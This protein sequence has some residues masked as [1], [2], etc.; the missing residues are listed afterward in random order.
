MRLAIEIAHS[1]GTGAVTIHNCSHTGRLGAYAEMA[2]AAGMLGIVAVNAGGG[3]QLVAPFG[4]AARRISTNPIA[5]GAPSPGAHPI[6]LDM[7]TSVAPEGKVR[8]AYQ[9]GKKLPDGVLVDARGVPT[10]D[11]A[12]LYADPPGSLRP[13]GGDF[14]HKGF[15]LA[16]L[17]DILAG[18]LTGA[19]VC[20]EGGTYQG[21]GMLLIVLDVAHFTPIN[22][23]LPR[24]A[25]LSDWIKT[26][27]PAPGFRQTHI[28]GELEHHT[29]TARLRDGIPI[30]PGSWELIER[31]AAHFGVEVPPAIGP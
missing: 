2:A 21:D 27:P 23:F 22:D 16:F 17:V 29:R 15:G 9:A 1:A 18:A 30:E 13:L 11:P 24:V 8:A 6:V 26:C 7:A 5:I 25:T 14:G 12:A 28:P 31:A 10:T 19:G 3:G 4:G 20:R